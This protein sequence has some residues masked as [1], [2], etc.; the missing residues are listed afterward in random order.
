MLEVLDSIPSAA[1]KKKKKVFDVLFPGVDVMNHCGFDL[2]LC[3]DAGA[4]SQSSHT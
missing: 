3:S 1:K 2:N 4:E